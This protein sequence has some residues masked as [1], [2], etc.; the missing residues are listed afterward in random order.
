MIE[1]QQQERKDK[2]RKRE[3]SNWDWFL[4]KFDDGNYQDRV[5]V[6]ERKHVDRRERR[7]PHS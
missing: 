4:K 2:K 6:S 1:R 5:I 7:R 3:K